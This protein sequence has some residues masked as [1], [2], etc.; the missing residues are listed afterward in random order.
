MNVTVYYDYICPFSYIGTKRILKLAEEMD[1]E[2]KW[3][4]IEIHPNYPASGKPRKRTPRLIHITQT[5]KDIAKAD[6]TRI[7]LPGFI[8]NSRLCLESAEFAR[9]KDKFMQFHN[10]TYDAF[11]M[12]RENIGDIK[13]IRNIASRSGMDPDELEQSL[14]KREMKS[15][16]DSNIKQ[17]EENMVLGVPTI[18]FNNFRVH[19]VQTPEDYRNLIM[20][21]FQREKENRLN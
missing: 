19:G 14:R 2:I 5:L 3:V 12:K 15:K 4:G 16:I 17:A 13:V 1:L 18:Y 20:K 8:T 7:Q 9:S 10:N 6:N 21:E 11:F